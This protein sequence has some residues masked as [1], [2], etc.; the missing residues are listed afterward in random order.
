[1][2]VNT[3]RHLTKR[4]SVVC[5]GDNTT[6][7]D[8]PDKSTNSRA[9][10]WSETIQKSFECYLNDGVSSHIMPNNSSLLGASIGA[11]GQQTKKLAVRA[12]I[13]MLKLLNLPPCLHQSCGEIENSWW[14]QQGNKEVYDND[15]GSVDCEMTQDS[16]IVAR[17][18]FFNKKVKDIRAH[19]H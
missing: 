3:G 5:C 1:M 9:E 12:R 18:R 14:D 11:T 10:A 15:S 19:W 6:E 13:K 17:R 16:L 7:E 4:R 8:Q 2:V